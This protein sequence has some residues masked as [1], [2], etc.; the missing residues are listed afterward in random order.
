MRLF[1]LML[2][3]FMC[4]G[5]VWGQENWVENGSMTAGE[6]VPS[7][8]A[9]FKTDEGPGQIK[10]ARDTGT[11]KTGPASLRIEAS[12]GSAKGTVS[13]K[14]PQAGGKMVRIKAWLKTEGNVTFGALAFVCPGSDKPW[15][16]IHA[17]RGASDWQEI[18]ARIKLPEA[19]S[20]PLLLLLL[21]G[22][23]KVWLDEVSVSPAGEY[24][25]SPVITK[26]DSMPMFAFLTWE[27]KMQLRED[28]IY[29][30]AP[31]GKGGMGFNA[32][33][34]F[35]AFADRVPALTLTLGPDNKAAKIRA[36]IGDSDGASYEFIYDLKEV[37]PGKKT[38]VYPEKGANLRHPNKAGK[39]GEAKVLDAGKI[40]QTAVIGDWKNTPV[41]IT[42]HQLEL[43]EASTEMKAEREKMLQQQ[44]RQAARKAEEAAEKA[45]QATELLGNAPHPEDGPNLLEISPVSSDLIALRIQEQEFY[46]T[47]QEA[48]V[49]EP[50]DKIEYKGE[51][52]PVVEHGVRTNKPK[53]VLVMRPPKPDAKKLEKLGN[54]A[55]NV[56]RIKK[57]NLVVGQEITDVTIDKPKAYLIKGA[58][59]PNWTDA[60][61]PV[62]VSWKRKPNADN[63]LAH[64]VEVFLKL[65]QPLVPGK[66]YS[67]Q[68][69]GVNLR[70]PAVRFTYNPRKTRSI[71][72][73]VTGIGFRPD[74]PYKT[75]WL[76]QW[77]GTG[78]DYA[79]DQA[80]D[81]EIIDNK[82]EETVY[83]GKIK[84]VLTPEQSESFK[85]G[86]NYSKT[87]VY[88]MDFSDLKKAGNY[89]VYVDGVGCSYPFDIAD[90]TWTKAFQLSMTGLL[91]HR[92]GMELGP[93]FTS[94]IRPRNFHPEDGVKIFACEVS[95]FEADGQNGK[96]KEIIKHTSNELVPTAWGG[97]M[98]AG[99][100]DRNGQHP[101][102]F[103]ILMD[104]YEVF[105]E[106]IGAIKLALP[107]E[108]AQNNIPDILD[109]TLWNLDFHLRN[110]TADGGIRTAVESTSHPRPGETSW[111]ESLLIA[112]MAPDPSVSYVYAADAAKMA[113][114]LKPFDAA[115]ADR[116]LESARKAWKWAVDHEQ[117]F[118]DKLDVKRLEKASRGMT[119]VRNLAALELW[120]TTDEKA[121]H[122]D[123]AKTSI[124]P[125]DATNKDIQR[126]SHMVYAR[127]PEGKGD[128]ELKRLA[129]EWLI[130]SADISLQFA[131][132]NA[133]GLS[134]SLPQ[135][136][137]MGY[138]RY[139]SVPE[140][141]GA[142]L[143]YAW[144]VT[145]EEKYLKGAIRACQFSAGANPDNR[146]FTTGLGPDPVQYPLHV[147]RAITGQPVPTGITVYGISDP[148][149][150]FEFDAW[151]YQWK[152]TRMVPNA[153]TWPANESYWDIKSVPSTCEYTIHQTII[154]SAF[155][156]G[157]LA[158]R[159]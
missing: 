32:P 105:P 37:E 69:E 48:Y 153:R 78:G 156:W 74:D 30:K 16:Q 116:Y 3:V 21:Q 152:L 95:E 18:N 87:Y 117:E 45:A 6:N 50:G 63:G 148:A 124:L 137:P 9:D 20:G 98:D 157:F 70:Q 147:D 38:T 64:L 11:Y 138:V 66:T 145:G 104:L 100:W 159:D 94:Y 110:Q 126:K 112:I 61:N 133:F 26:F 128:P 97:H 33:G 107:P 55:V 27:K 119:V 13:T 106:K 24:V 4:A 68:F 141:I 40:S 125:T 99:D 25:A 62:D 121:Y 28:G 127:L 130:E 142:I 154:P 132:G 90:D 122:D 155:Y 15:N 14:I 140:M 120:V 143:P 10:I 115:K 73:H 39:D 46:Y 89:R 101:L 85:E 34:D 108:E 47:P 76:S 65:P 109:E 146:A 103:W 81:F 131:E 5:F 139:F 113:R 72:V 49:A 42:V 136:P 7:G 93:P 36:T 158:A 134:T 123:F 53:E 151:V 58:D 56:N 77:M 71:A 35:S 57:D 86:R 84:Q 29:L 88:Q 41:E 83:R 102:A 91:N 2:L 1:I 52:L 59:D 44:A 150:K 96:F 23:G 67:I 114:L 17:F 31:E 19:D 54:L 43:A 149:E 129:K 135:L 8:W 144:L 51:E 75:A 79:F 118:M 60:V 22:E 82:T 80:E 12:G 111:Q 92:A